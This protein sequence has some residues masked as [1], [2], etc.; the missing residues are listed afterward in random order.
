M[1]KVVGKSYYNAFEAHPNK[2]DDLV[3]MMQ[4]LNVSSKAFSRPASKGAQ[5]LA[6]EAMIAFERLMVLD[7]T[8]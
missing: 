4:S 2:Q 8:Y 6:P 5:T 3:K 7:M 1:Q